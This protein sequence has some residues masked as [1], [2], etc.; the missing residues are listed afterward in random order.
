MIYVCAARTAQQFLNAG[1]L[2]EISLCLVPVVPGGGVRLLDNPGG[3][4]LSPECTQVTESDDV[5]H[6]K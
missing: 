6:L 4:Q 5:T 2:D 1:L 3:R